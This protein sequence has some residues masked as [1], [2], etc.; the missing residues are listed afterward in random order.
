MLSSAHLFFRHTT[1]KQLCYEFF[2]K[3]SRHN[4]N[5]IKEH[6]F[7][8]VVL[9]VL[10]NQLWIRI[11]VHRVNV[12]SRS[13]TCVLAQVRILLHDISICTAFVPVTGYCRIINQSTHLWLLINTLN[14][15]FK[16]D[17]TTFITPQ[18]TDV[19]VECSEKTHKSIILSPSTS[20]N[21]PRP[22]FPDR[23]VFPNKC[24]VYW[25][26]QKIAIHVVMSFI[27]GSSRTN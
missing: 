7:I 19:A 17:S 9:W 22:W 12:R 27:K 13:V 3:Q 1:L 14:R 11:E 20:S 21:W 25:F 15:A 5:F 16:N 4:S 23:L 8:A 18:S 24:F 6:R 10:E 2:L 26:G